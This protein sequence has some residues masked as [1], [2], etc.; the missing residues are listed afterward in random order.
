MPLMM[1]STSAKFPFI[2]T[3]YFGQ[4]AIKTENAL[5]MSKPSNMHTTNYDT[6]P[7]NSPSKRVRCT[8]NL[9]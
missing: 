3:T 2:Q 1:P 5:I 7:W 8:Q 6:I 4:L 9:H